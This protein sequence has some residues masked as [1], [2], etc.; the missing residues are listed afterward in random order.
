MTFLI[1]IDDKFNEI[2]YLKKKHKLLFICASILIVIFDGIL[3]STSKENYIL[4]MI[5]SIILT[6]A[7]FFYL[8]FYFS[9]LRI[10]IFD[11]YRLFSSLEKKVFCEDK[12]EFIEYE[13]KKE[14]SNGIE[15]FVLNMN[16]LNNLENVVKKFYV[17]EKFPFK[18]NKKYQINYFGK[19]IV[20]CEECK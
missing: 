3:L 19:V 5:F 9:I 17:L 4:N 14:I 11:E 10:K 20:A 6:I 8:I 16:V 12:C 13:D 7:Y 15:Y 2:S 18:K 1:D